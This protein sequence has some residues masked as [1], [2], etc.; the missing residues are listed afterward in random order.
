MDLNKNPY[1]LYTIQS[2]ATLDNAL[3]QIGFGK[4]NYIVILL[5]GISLSCVF[6]ETVSINIILPIAQCDLDLSTQQ[7][8]M[9]SSVGFLGI[10][11]SSH[12]WGFLADTKGRKSVIIPT[13]FMASLLSFV[14][15][16]AKS[17]EFL[18]FLRLLNGVL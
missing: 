16:F 14:S 6:F 17:F 1:N 15:C 4:F 12:M 3:S 8:S 10:I 9:L 11:L 13:L 2:R 18:L 5:T 7:K